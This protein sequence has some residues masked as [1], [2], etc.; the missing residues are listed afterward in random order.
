M[1]IPCASAKID[2]DNSLSRNG[3]ITG[4]AA[5]C[6]PDFVNDSAGKIKQ[7]LGDDDNDDAHKN[8]KNYDDKGEEYEYVLVVPQKLTMVAKHVLY[9]KRDITPIHYHLEGRF[10]SRIHKIDES[11]MGLPL[12]TAS[13]PSS[14]SSSLMVGDQLLQAKTKE[15]QEKLAKLTFQ[16]DDLRKLLDMDGVSLTCK[17]YT[18]P[19]SHLARPPPYIDARI[20]PERQPHSESELLQGKKKRGGTESDNSNNTLNEPITI[21]HEP[22]LFSYVE[23]FAGMGGFGIALDSLGGRCVFCS[24]LEEHLQKICE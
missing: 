22:P 15:A 24:E 5:C 8:N 6:G 11:H 10:G 4:Q 21:Y 23:L 3:I 20:H 14:S 17:L 9:S 16:Y 1:T 7:S 12:F 13:V 19:R 18:N 2:V